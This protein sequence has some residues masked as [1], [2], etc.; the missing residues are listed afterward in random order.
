MLKNGFADS[1]FVCFPYET[2]RTGIYTAGAVRA[3]MDSAHAR[4]D[5][6]GAT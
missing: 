2:R 6:L 3:P 4:E 1:H 5:A